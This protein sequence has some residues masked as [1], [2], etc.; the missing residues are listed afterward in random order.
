L[1]Y[2]FIVAS[3]LS[4]VALCDSAGN[5]FE[6]NLLDNSNNSNN[7]NNNFIS[8]AEIKLII[9]KKHKVLYDL[10]SNAKLKKPKTDQPHSYFLD[11]RQAAFFLLFEKSLK[12]EVNINELV[13]Y[14]SIINKYLFI[15][16]GGRYSELGHFYYSD[17][18][19]V[20]S[21]L[22]LKLARTHRNHIPSLFMYD[23]PTRH[24]LNLLEGYGINLP[25]ILKVDPENFSD[26]MAN[27]YIDILKNPLTV[28][29]FREK[30]MVL[31]KTF[32]DD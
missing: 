25:G 7:V 14:K 18:C 30:H 13:N 22:Y 6:D 27:F 29:D 28:I 11:N 8:D 2:A 10:V 19:D 1:I 17:K 23:E 31:I 4:A 3:N 21:L 24:H 5:L 32:L 12:P 9:D 15:L 20:D 26:S 16:N